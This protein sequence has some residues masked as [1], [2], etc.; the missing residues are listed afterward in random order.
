MANCTELHTMEE[1]S[2][3]APSF[4]SNS[5]SHWLS[6]YQMRALTRDS[7]DSRLRPMNC[8][9]PPPSQVHGN[10]RAVKSHPLA[11]SSTSS[12]PPLQRDSASIVHAWCLSRNE[13]Q[14][15]LASTLLIA[16]CV[17]Y[18]YMVFAND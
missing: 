17:F 15:L 13:S 8:F 10:L 9:A 18:R 7:P 6:N 12:T 4:R 2:S 5:M 1:S 11:A 16:G 3:G 14:L